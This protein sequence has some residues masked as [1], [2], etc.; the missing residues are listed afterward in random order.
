M[1]P[2]RSTAPGMHGTLTAYRFR[3]GRLHFAVRRTQP[4]RL[5][6]HRPCRHLHPARH[7][8]RR[9]RRHRRLQRPLHSYRP[10]LMAAPGRLRRPR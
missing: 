8:Q 5:H 10:G 7:L 4:Q 6:L 9:H 3:T 2:S 1:R